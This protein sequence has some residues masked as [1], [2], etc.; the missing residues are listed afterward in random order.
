[1]A[2]RPDR[3]ARRPK[4]TARSADKHWLYQQSVQAPEEDSRFFAR[5]Y[6][7]CTGRDARVF[8]EDFCG[9]ALLSCHWVRLHRSNR[10][11]GVDIHGPTLDWG[12][13]N[14]VADLLDPSQQRRL[15]LLRRNVLRAGGPRTDIVAALNFSYSVFKTRDALRAYFAAARAALRDGGLFFVDVWGGSETQVVQEESREVDGF[16]YVWDQH[17]FDPL[18]YET[19]CRIHFEFRDGTRLRNAFTY[20]WR[21]WT[22]PELRELMAEVGLREIH[23][24]WEATDRKTGEGNGVFRRV[25][26]GEPDLAWIAYVVGRR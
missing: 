16:T 1:M 6:R 15:T 26:K 11:I 24:L 2:K 17:S 13:R 18:T 14:N 8:R 23:V 10:A 21:L 19:T 7:R 4:L 20:D 25:T 9:T 12:R 3:R 22:L 5:H